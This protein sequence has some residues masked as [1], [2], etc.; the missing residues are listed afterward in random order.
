V[1]RVDYTTTKVLHNPY[2]N[3]S[4]A[5]SLTRGTAFSLTDVTLTDQSVDITTGKIVAEQIDRAD[6]AQSGYALQMERAARQGQAIN[7][8][9]ES[10]FLGDYAAMTTFDNTELGGSA[11]NITVSSTNIDDIVTNLKRKIY[12]AAGSDLYHQNGGFVIWR[13]ADFQLLENFAMS[14][15]FVQADKALGGGVNGVRGFDYMGLTHYVSNLGTAGK[16]VAG[17]KKVYHL[18]ILSSTYGAVTVSDGEAGLRSSIIITS[19]A[20]FKGKLWNNTAGLVYNVT[21]A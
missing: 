3:L 4:T 20:D 7:K 17:V 14:N 16:I 10:A 6:L 8:A 21:V 18:G 19:R 12:A 2:Q 13:P 5:A 9:I 15:G 1:C 11:G